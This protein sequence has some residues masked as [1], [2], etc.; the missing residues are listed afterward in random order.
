[1]PFPHVVQPPQIGR[2]PLGNYDGQKPSQSDDI[3]DHP[4]I[5]VVRLQRRVVLDFLHLLRMHGE[6][7]RSRLFI[8]SLLGGYY[9]FK[10]GNSKL[11]WEYLESCSEH[12]E[13]IQGIEF[14]VSNGFDLCAYSF[15][16]FDYQRVG[17]IAPTI[18]GLIE[19][20]QTQAEFHEKPFNPYSQILAMWGFATGFLGHFDKGERLLE[21]ALSFAEE[22]NHRATL[23]SVQCLYGILLAFKGDGL[24]TIKMIK[25]AIKDLEESQTMLFGGQAWTFLGY[26]H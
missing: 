11:G 12:P 22:I 25:K 19:N 6:D 2:I 15:I 5:L 24:S 23:G 17:R 20:S 7:D 9:I 18:I 10:G 16:L 14:L 4:R 26:G 1:V 3:R 8:R 21:K 13:S